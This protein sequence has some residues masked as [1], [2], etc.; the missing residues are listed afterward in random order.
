MCYFLSGI[1]DCMDVRYKRLASNSIW[2]LAG[3]TGSKIIG[4]L[5]LPLYTRWLGTNGFGES[6][7]VTTY[8]TVLM[9]I[10]TLSISEAIF[11]FTKN[12]NEAEKKAY[13]SSSLSFVAILLGI[14]M[15]IW[16]VLDFV[17]K[18][19]NIQ[20]SFSNNLW[21]IYA[22]VVFS[23]LQQFFQQFVLGVEKIKIYALTGIVH[24]IMTFAFSYWLIP[25]MGVRGYIIAM[26]GSYLV[27]A[28]YTFFFSNSVK[29]LIFCQLDNQKIK[30]ILKYSI[31][32]IPNG[33]MW[34]LISAINRPM[35][36]HYLDY[37]AIGIFAVANRFP[38]VITMIFTV[39]ATAWNISVFE[40]YGKKGY[41]EFY[42]K[43][44]RV[45]FLLL[46][47]VSCIVIILSYYIIKVF[48]APEFI[49]AWK[50]MIIL[51]AGSFYYCICSFLGTNFGVVKKSKYFFYSSIYGALSSVAL[52]YL[53]IP[54]YG[55]W[56][57]SLSV[58]ISYIIMSIA[59]YVYSLKY[60]KVS[61][62]PSVLEFS[63]LLAIVCIVTIFVQSVE[64][65]ILASL[66]CLSVYV[67]Y[68]R[69]IILSALH[70]I[71]K[72]NQ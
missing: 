4:F 39:F 51:V 14:W 20:N 1:V 42:K 10:M 63:L 8:A 71:I 7:L 67:L 61:L 32:L 3:N 60:V 64:I 46:T 29:Y 26:I 18:A 16:L 58:L 65:K 13:F 24:T 59:R 40:E 28:L 72:R 37:S 6:D 56:G 30:E 66:A 36:E 47:I 50:Y 57:A 35:M 15:L 48:T 23:F 38:G 21:Y 19:K 52:N 53:L 41:E 43:T 49:E 54:K 34:W 22:L 9:C 2:T 25:K 62:I 33:I 27:T 31:P 11:V 5:L 55:L 70:N 12:K 17:F 69:E 45:L 68:E 44:F